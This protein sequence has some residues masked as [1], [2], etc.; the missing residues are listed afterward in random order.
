M[1]MDTRFEILLAIFLSSKVLVTKGI[2]TT[3]ISCEPGTFLNNSASRCEPC[4]PGY[5]CLTSAIDQPSGMCA[6]G[7]YCK[8]GA[9][10][11]TPTDGITGNMCDRGYYCPRGSAGPTPCPTGT[12]GSQTAASKC[13]NCSSDSCVTEDRSECKPNQLVVPANSPLD[14]DRR[15]VIVACNGVKTR[16]MCCPA[17][18][19]DRIIFSRQIKSI[20][21]PFDDG[22]WTGGTYYLSSNRRILVFHKLFPSLTKN[23]Y[24]CTAA[25]SDSSRSLNVTIKISIQECKPE[26]CSSN[27]SASVQTMFTEGSTDANVNVKTGSNTEMICQASRYLCHGGDNL[28]KLVND[29]EMRELWTPFELQWFKLDE[30]GERV[31]IVNVATTESISQSEIK[32]TGDFKSVLPLHGITAADFGTYLCETPDGQTRKYHLIS[33]DDGDCDFFILCSQTLIDSQ[34][35]VALCKYFEAQFGHKIFIFERDAEVGLYKS[36]NLRRGILSSRRILVILSPYFVQESWS[37]GALEEAKL[38]NKQISFC[39]FAPEVTP[40]CEFLQTDKSLAADFERCDRK[41]VWS[42][43]YAHFI[44]F[45]PGPLPA[46]DNFEQLS[47]GGSILPLRCVT[48]VK[49]EVTTCRPCCPVASVGNDLRQKLR[50]LRMMRNFQVFMIKLRSFLPKSKSISRRRSGPGS[51]SVSLDSKS[52]SSNHQLLISPTVLLD[53]KYNSDRQPVISNAK[54]SNDRRPVLSNAKRSNDRQPVSSYSKCSRDHFQPA[55]AESA[56]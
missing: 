54:Y 37:R 49:V 29:A 56:T 38:F 23:D 35:A 22:R 21:E 6:P 19:Y 9:V 33:S 11:G 25:A 41:V 4:P 28:E 18:G 16:I 8:G 39:Y 7:Y 50:T 1:D 51:P 46:T 13:V 55:L 31:K 36:E 42:P 53:S 12:F 26:A 27:D 24:M 17:P 34:L 14:D 20:W 44:D 3:R 2:T 30:N 45:H 32:Y 15:R 40:T 52:S 5:F 10:T 43:E 48:E 47:N